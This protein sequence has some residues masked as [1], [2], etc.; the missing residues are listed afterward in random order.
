MSIRYG[1]KTA[2]L[3]DKEISSSYLGFDRR[4]LSKL[5]ILN[6]TYTRP[7][8]YLTIPSITSS[9]EK[10]VMLVFISDN[11]SN[12]LAFTFSGNCTV[13]WGDGL[14][15]NV[16]SGVAAS[17]SY[18][19]ST[20]DPSNTTL[21]SKGFKQALVTVTAQ[22][23]SSLTSLN[24]QTRHP[25]TTGT[26]NYYSQPIVELYISCPN[27]TSTNLTLGTNL[28]TVVYP[29]L[30]EYVNL[31]N[32]GNLTALNS[33]FRTMYNLKR[34]DIGKTSSLLTSMV[35]T[36]TDCRSLQTVTINSETN[37]SNVTSTGGMFSNCYSL[38]DV[39][40]LNTS[41][42]TAMNI[43]FSNCHSLKRVPFFNT[44]KVTNM[45]SM[46][47]NC[48][49]LVEVPLFD[50]SKVTEMGT[51]FDVCYSLETVP[52]F[53]TVA[54]TNMGGMFRNCAS[55]TRVPLFNTSSVTN[56]NLMFSVCRSLQAVPL[57]NT[58]NVTDM[59]S[60]FNDCNSL[61]KV[62]LF[63]TSKVI[64]MGTMFNGCVYLEQVPFLNTENVTNMAQMFRFCYSLTEVPLFNTVKVTTMT[65]MFESCFSLTTVP[66]F[67][68][69][70]VTAMNLMFNAC[71]SLTSVP[72]FNTIKVTSMASMFQN[73]PSLLKIPAFNCTAL[74]TITTMFNGAN[75]L[76]EI[77]VMNF[78]SVTVA[79]TNAFTSLSLASFLA[80]NLKVTFSLAGNKLSKS[81][82]ETVFNNLGIGTS[83]TITIS[84]TWGALGAISPAVTETTTADSTL[85]SLTD[86]SNLSVGMQVVGANTPITT[87]RAVTFTDAGD[88]VNLNSHGLSD[89]DEVAFSA[90]TTTTGI[91]INTI[92][93]VVNAAANTFQVASSIGGAALALTTNGSGTV[94]YNSTIVSINP[95]VSLTMS[96]PMA[97]SGTTSLT[98]RSLGTYKA[99][100]KGWTVTG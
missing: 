10:V 100:L 31:I 87:G 13:D 37:T 52:L 53:N 55:L 83:Q 96:R 73:C 28:A 67:D 58:V 35:S 84:N 46:F 97:V 93:Y 89:G 85:I 5:P 18:N 22:G 72:L 95:N 64:N 69:S 81:A 88:L 51:M 11:D 92:Y 50:T 91:V 79:T 75:N 26:T 90:I 66:L 38:I 21:N 29:R 60:M 14:V 94:K 76:T 30:T 16:S 98:F 34:V 8:D 6:P 25:F 32:I 36:F 57:F 68:T 45:L 24:F 44:S 56:M 40:L 54:V 78:N 7:S 19:Y 17:H 43:M 2:T 20:Y 47:E 9:D 48:H 70:N 77:P 80:T 86:T 63:N 3:S 82:L 42:V 62:P 49:S 4:V 23:G 99:I 27:L 41:N 71:W 74:T 61:E 12:L 1:Q 39:P 59:S 33:T 65:S 15:E